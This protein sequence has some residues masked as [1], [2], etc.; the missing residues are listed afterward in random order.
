MV[1]VVVV[2]VV[3]GQGGFEMRCSMERDLQIA[4]FRFGEAGGFAKSQTG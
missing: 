4:A 3:V 2:V 1:V